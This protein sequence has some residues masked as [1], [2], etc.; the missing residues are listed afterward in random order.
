[1]SLLGKPEAQMGPVKGM[2]MWP[3][4]EENSIKCSNDDFDIGLKILT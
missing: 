3:N 2:H 4:L 1:M